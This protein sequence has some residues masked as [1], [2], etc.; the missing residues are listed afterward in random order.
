MPYRDPR[1]AVGIDFGGTFIKM[2]LVDDEGRIVSRRK[3]PTRQLSGQAAWLDALSGG[4]K[5]LAAAGVA[6]EAVTLSGLGIGVPGFVDFERGHIFTLPNVAGW[7]NVQLA[8]LMEE[9][10]GLRVRVDNDVNVMA[11]GECTFGAGRTFQHAVFITLGTGVG[12]ALL[13]NNRMYRGAY[14]MAGEIGHMTVDLNG[15]SSPT[16]FGGL[17]QYVGNRRIVER[18]IRYL[19][20]GQPSM[21]DEMCGGDRS[22]IDPRMIDEAASQGDQVGI[23]VYD[24]TADYLAAAL[25]SVTY[26]LQPQAFIIGGGVGQSGPPLYDPLRR[27]LQRRLSPHFF[28]RVQIKKASLGNDAG[29]IGGAT[30][31]LME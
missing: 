19:E 1:Y 4:V 23:T 27:H 18:A 12:G 14:H 26:L 13:L 2:A 31:V 7:E 25:A 21:L 9:R 24:E 3:I 6:G 5:E 29:V 17:E 22:Q 10:T 11:I 15:I 28:D 20:D 8:A 16:G 30:M